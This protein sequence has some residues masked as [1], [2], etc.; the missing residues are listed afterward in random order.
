MLLLFM[1]HLT[2]ITVIIV[3]HFCKYGSKVIYYRK[4]YNLRQVIF[5]R[6]RNQR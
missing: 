6:K 2:T 5:M 4:V 1:F 3:M